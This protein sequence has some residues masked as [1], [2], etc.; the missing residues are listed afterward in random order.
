MMAQKRLNTGNGNIVYWVN[1]NYNKEYAL[2]FLHGLTADH[3]L[4]EK[5]IAH[6]T[7]RFKVVCWDT[8]AHGKSRPY[9]NFSYHNIA[10]HLKDILEKERV[11]RAVFIGQSMGGFITQ[12]FLKRYPEVVI[13]FVV[14]DTTPSDYPIILLQ[15]SGGSGR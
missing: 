12:S 3:T 8:P 10:E 9:I 11:S 6:F 2:V 1:D 5:Q 15:I 14:I 4:F 13:G 7:E